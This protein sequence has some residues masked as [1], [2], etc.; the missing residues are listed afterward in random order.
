MH[1]ELHT[2]VTGSSQSGFLLPGGTQTLEKTEVSL[3][4]SSIKLLFSEPPK[5]EATL[6]NRSFSRT[7]ICID[8]TATKRYHERHPL[9]VSYLGFMTDSVSSCS[10]ISLAMAWIR[11]RSIFAKIIQ[12]DCYFITEKLGGNRGVSRYLM[13]QRT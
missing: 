10:K 5:K 1:S 11:F 8:S 9:I 4:E 12:S 13:K 6:L 7:N 2:R 3:S